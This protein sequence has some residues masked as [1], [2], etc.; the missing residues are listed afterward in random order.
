M[1]L[2]QDTALDILIGAFDDINVRMDEETLGAS[3]ARTGIMNIN[4]IMAMFAIN[5]VDLGFTKLVNINDPITIPEGVTDS[6]ISIL[7]LRLW[8]KYRTGDARFEVAQ[9]ARDGVKQMYK[10]GITI[11]VTEYPN[12][13]PRGSGNS[14]PGWD[15][16]TFYTDLSD[17]ILAENSGSISLEDNTND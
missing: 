9:N 17:T 16:N 8:P 10:T 12:T 2:T 5:G 3:D 11:G 7:A 14:S 1:S 4:R 6:L 13:L 15:D